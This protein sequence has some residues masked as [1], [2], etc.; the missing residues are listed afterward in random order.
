MNHRSSFAVLLLF[1]FCLT[2]N[3]SHI[4]G[5]MPEEV[6]DMHD[7]LTQHDVD[8]CRNYHYNFERQA[9]RL[10]ADNQADS[11][12]DAIEFIKTEC[13]PASNLELFRTLLLT[14][15]GRYDDTLIGSSTIPQMVWYRAEQ[16]YRSVFNRWNFLYGLSRP[17]DN[18]HDNFERLNTQLAEQISVDSS[19][20]PSARVIGLYYSGNFDTAMSLI[21]SDQCRGTALQA[22]YDD[23]VTQVKNMFPTRGNVAFLVGAW[24]P[25][26]NIGF[27]GD[28]PNFGIQLG[29][30][31]KK[32][33]GDLVLDLRFVDSKNEYIV[34]DNGSLVSTDEY[35][36]LLLGIEI[37]RK[38][39]DNRSFS[40][41]VFVGLGYEQIVSGERSDDPDQGIIHGSIAPSIGLRQR[42]FLNDHTGWYIGGNIRYSYADYSNRG[43]TDLSGGAVTVSF[44]TGWSMH[45]TLQQFLKAI[46][47]KGS[48]RP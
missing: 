4:S 39:F 1:A 34:N 14:H 9:P 44:I 11:I 45:A 47:Y 42:F 37:G 6:A 38:L 48:W 15:A 32:W 7:F 3:C 21:Q 20:V 22:A 13:G 27:L 25:Q 19:A 26:N 41:D 40:T 46:N 28:H 5:R 31:G 36:G 24:M 2:V 33:R 18:T 29:G 23:Y 17:I 8:E 10:Y 35:S 30:E 12:L 43:G 16:D